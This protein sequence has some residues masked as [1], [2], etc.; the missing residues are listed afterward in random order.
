[1]KDK[2]HPTWYE[3]ARVTCS[4]GSIFSVG[5]T[6]E[7]IKTE[8]CSQCHPLFTG[9]EKLID[10]EGRVERF[11]KKRQRAEA[12][13]RELKAKEESKKQKGVREYRPRTL[14]EMLDYASKQVS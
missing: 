14:K 10:T 13:S 1:M 9:Q 3:S 11:E 12:S 5:S 8:I 6:L 7:S 2:V 4:C